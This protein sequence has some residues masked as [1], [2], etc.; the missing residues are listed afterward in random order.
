MGELALG[1]VPV[2]ASGGSS[3]SLVAKLGKLAVFLL[4]LL[5]LLGCFEEEAEAAEELTVLVERYFYSLIVLVL[6]DRVVDI[7]ELF[8]DRRVHHVRIGAFQILLLQDGVDDR[9]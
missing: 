5:L 4:L 8:R 7:L 3:L 6:Q 2:F 9:A 1:V